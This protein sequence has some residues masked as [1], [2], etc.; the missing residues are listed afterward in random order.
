MKLT[1][2]KL[3][4]WDLD[5]TFWTGNLGEGTAVFSNKNCNFVKRLIDKGIMNS[6]CSKNNFSDVE[7][8]FQEKQGLFDLFIFKS[9]N[10]EPKGPRIKELIEQAQL[11]PVNVLFIDDNE[12]NI[13]E[14]K[15]YNP[16][17]KTCMPDEVDDLIVQVDAIDKKDEK[18][19]RLKQYKILEIKSQEKQKIG[20]NDKFLEE[21]D[22]HVSIQHD[23]M[24]QCDRLYEL[25]I[26]SN[27]LNYTKNRCSKEEFIQILHDKNIETGYVKCFDKYGDYGVI[28]FYALNK[29]KHE[30]LHFFFSCR[31]LGMGVEQYVYAKLGFPVL[32]VEG[33]VAVNVVQNKWVSYIKDGRKHSIKKS[34]SVYTKR[35][36]LKGPCDLSGIM[37]YLSN[38]LGIDTEFVHANQNRATTLS[39]ETTVCAVDAARLSK[40]DI[41]KI[42]QNVPMLSQEDYTT[43]IYDSRYDV[44]V[45][46]MLLDCQLGLYR[47]KETGI[48]FPFG[49]Y[50]I[51]ITDRQYEDI[52]TGSTVYAKEYFLTKSDLDNF[53][54][55]LEFLG[56]ISPDS[57]VKNLTYIRNH[58]QP[59]TKLVLV[60]GSEKEPVSE[61]FDNAGLYLRHRLVNKAIREWAKTQNNV[62]I[63]NLTDFI[64]SA[65]DYRDT[66]NHFQ[67]HIYYKLAQRVALE[68]SDNL[69]VRDKKF[70]KSIN[71]NKH[72]RQTYENGS[73]YS[74]EQLFLHVFGIKIPLSKKHKKIVANG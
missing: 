65:E 54:K 1:D 9:I 20:S 29:R 23:C 50:Q 46:S 5:D 31:T 7:R 67:R 60:L 45:F 69:H 38:N 21:S 19:A 44:I 51:P 33:Q 47:D 42:L 72:R 13:N 17:I 16:D 39:Q 30:L 25:L 26:R 15:Y 12:L 18:H 24:K 57:L 37:P 40:T 6:I 28:G 52:W 2:I 74:H 41:N 10:W 36:L 4:V 53:R 49:N 68:I 73:Y 22:I 70:W 59:S 64:K 43:S 35:V 8:K 11:R 58:I 14:V 66:V 48:V 56:P 32:R 63:I 55:T 34:A 62:T 3:I 61:L 27:Q 71:I